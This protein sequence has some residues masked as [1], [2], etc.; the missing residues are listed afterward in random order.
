VTNRC[1]KTRGEIA[2]K[3]VALMLEKMIEK[4]RA[5]AR[6]LEEL[7]RCVAAE[8]A[9][10]RQREAV[11]AARLD[12]TRA[13]LAEAVAARDHE[14][15]RRIESERA[16]SAIR[17]AIEQARQVLD[18]LSAPPAAQAP[19]MEA[20]LAIDQAETGLS[21]PPADIDAPAEADLR[22]E[23]PSG[24]SRESSDEIEGEPSMDHPVVT[25]TLSPE[26]S[27]ALAA[28]A[29]QEGFLDG[30]AYAAHLVREALREVVRPAPPPGIAA[31]SG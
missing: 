9:D 31:G 6:D 8:A 30:A 15:D 25:L 28:R 22:D 21:G 19:A 5:H 14:R 7:S 12:E 26:E 18:A 24:G 2:T 11:W 20:P 23:G 10:A 29:A 4:N 1:E 3:S 17:A 16:V 13:E 27:A